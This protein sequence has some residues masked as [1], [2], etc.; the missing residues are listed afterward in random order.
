MRRIA[1]VLGLLAACS[2]DADSFRCGTRLVITGDPISRL[3][4]LCGQPA[5]KIKSREVVGRGSRAS[6]AGV[7]QWIYERGRRRNVVVSVKNGTVVK[8]AFE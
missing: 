4:T 5:L 2:A 6:S 3:I 8:I 1:A 7:S